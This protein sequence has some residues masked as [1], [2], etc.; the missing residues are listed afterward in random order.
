M[1]RII[2]ELASIDPKQYQVNQLA[3]QEAAQQWKMADSAEEC[4][5]GDTAIISWFSIGQRRDNG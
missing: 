1:C 4:R 2:R 5:A 3:A